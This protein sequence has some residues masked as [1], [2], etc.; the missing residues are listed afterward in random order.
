LKPDVTHIASALERA[1]IDPSNVRDEGALGVVVRVAVAETRVVLETLKETDLDFG[2]LVD[3]FGVDTGQGVAAVYHLRSFS[4]DQEIFVKVAH[5]Y[6]GDLPSVWELLPAVL[7]PEREL[8]EMFGLTL[9]GHPNPKHLL[10]SDASEPLLLKRIALR[11]PQEAR[12]R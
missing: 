12:D 3:L 4:R 5:E 10:L 2:F 9:S 6:G 7:M 1:G 11:T 8:A